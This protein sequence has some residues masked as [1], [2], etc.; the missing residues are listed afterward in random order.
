MLVAT[1]L[2]FGLAWPASADT[3]P[4][5]STQPSENS[6]QF[7][8]YVETQ[9]S[10]LFPNSF[11]GG[12]IAPTSVVTIY[13]VPNNPALATWLAQAD[14]TGVAYVVVPVTQSYS[15]LNGIQQRIATAWSSL[16]QDGIHINQSAPDPAL[17][18]ID[19]TLGPP[20]SADITALVGFLMR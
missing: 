19:I 6:M 3:S 20:S 1:S 18:T 14:T 12:Y 5:S 15:Q 8:D 2:V 11:S 4:S 17:S 7:G 10:Q 9:A 16:G 13:A